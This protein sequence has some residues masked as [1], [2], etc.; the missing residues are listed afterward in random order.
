M[1]VVKASAAA[2]AAAAIRTA[3]AKAIVVG[4]VE[5]EEEMWEKGRQALADFYR[6]PVNNTTAGGMSWDAPAPATQ[7]Q[8]QAAPKSSTSF[9]FSCFCYYWC[10]GVCNANHVMLTLLEGVGQRAP[11]GVTRSTDSKQARR[12]QHIRNIF[13]S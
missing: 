11:Y 7:T 10:R 5:E 6:S 12:W 8:R 2:A 13:A 1:A 9:F 4:V 3:A